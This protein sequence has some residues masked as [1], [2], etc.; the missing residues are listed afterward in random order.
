MP[1]FYNLLIFKPR[2]GSCSSNGL[3]FGKCSVRISG[4]I[5]AILSWFLQANDGSELKLGYGVFLLNPVYFIV[6]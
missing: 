2:A 3:D 4:G 1:D 6:H 5:Q